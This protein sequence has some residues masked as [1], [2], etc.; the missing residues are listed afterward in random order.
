MKVRRAST[1]VAGFRAAGVHCGIKAKAPDL[2]LIV[3]DRPASAAAVFTRS[4]VVGAPVE[5]SRERVRSGRT[6]GVVVNSGVSNVAM[7]QRGLRDARTMTRWAAQAIGC[8]EQELLV[9]ST[10]V[11]GEP[12]P[13][14]ALRSGIPE[15][16]S[17]LSPEG[18]R[19]AA[20]AI[21]TTDTHAK[22]ASVRLRL[23]GRPVTLTGI[24][25]GSGM[26]EPNMATMLSFLATDASVAPGLLRRLLRRTV[27]ATF[28]RLSVD[29]EGSTSDSVVLMASGAAEA[30][31]LRPGSPETA[32]FES[33]LGAVC[34]DLVRQLARDGEGATKLVTVRIDGARSRAEADLAS[35]RIGNSALVKTAVFGG[36]PNWGRI[37]QTLGAAR[38]AWSPER[39]RVKV[40]GVVVFSRGRSA[41]PAAR[42]RAERAMRAQE[43][44]IAVELGRGEASA[45]LFTCDLTYDYVRIN[46]EYTT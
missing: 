39:A 26:I 37:L 38:I 46:A 17:R 8:D 28:N 6:R 19:D 1:P 30:T 9:A 43:I 33:A 40:G 41:G 27:D 23:G 31:P 20:E 2:A 5:V 29:G 35:R 16:A 24:A 11:I 44:E 18:W 12:L 25:K 32:R 42:R 10:G 7:G 4:T 45:R 13:M 34:E 3:A 36:D 15:C 21:R 14:P 22:L